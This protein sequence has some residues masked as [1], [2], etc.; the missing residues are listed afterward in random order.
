MPRNYVQI[1]FIAITVFVIMLF[2][3]LLVAHAIK[4][5]N[6]YKAFK[7]IKLGAKESEI[8]SLFG[9]PKKTIIID[10]NTKVITYEV[11]EPFLIVFQKEHQVQ[12]SIQNSIV[13][14]IVF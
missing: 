7:N 9:V 8:I 12:I 11:I 1:I 13:T 10:E 4:H 2:A 14:N 6:R 5:N 3:C